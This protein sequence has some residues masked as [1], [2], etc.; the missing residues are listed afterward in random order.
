MVDPE[1]PRAPVLCSPLAVHDKVIVRPPRVHWMK[2]FFL[3][4]RQA[5]WRARL[6]ILWMGL[7]YALGL[8]VGATM[9]HLGNSFALSY[10][11]RLVRH[12]QSNSAAVGSNQGLPL[13]AAFFDFAGN[14]GSGAVPSTIMGI[15]IALPFPQ[16]A[17]RGWIGGIVSVDGH[18]QSRLRY[19][20]ERVYYLGILL[21]QLVPYSLAGGTG[22]RLGLA[23][24]MPK[25]RWGYSASERWLG[26]PSEGVRD[27]VRI[28]ILIIPLFLLASLVEFLAR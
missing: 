23:F 15:G 16:A 27:V 9:V 24:L 28:Y 26:L 2:T 5:L 18:H 10:R 4:I 17:Y 20:H 3:G 1:Y 11:D 13:R 7:T 8:S 19:W 25:G 6:P 22:V 12:A 21:M 14:L